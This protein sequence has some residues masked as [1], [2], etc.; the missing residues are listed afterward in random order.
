MGE[1]LDQR[2]TITFLFQRVGAS[3]AR[4][5]RAEE[6]A[7]T[8]RT[9]AP[10]TVP[11]GTT[12]RRSALTPVRP[13]QPRLRYETATTGGMRRVTAATVSTL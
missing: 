9:P 10:A 7:P 8:R 12:L 2:R 4:L 3:G 5:I 11:A 1:L 13:P 6:T